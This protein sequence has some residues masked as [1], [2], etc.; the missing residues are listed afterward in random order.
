LPLTALPSEYIVAR[1]DALDEFEGA[2]VDF[3]FPPRGEWLRTQFNDLKGQ[4]DWK[5]VM[6]CSPHALYRIAIGFECGEV[7]KIA[8]SRIARSLTVENVSSLYVFSPLD[9]R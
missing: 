7:Q 2:K 9:K 1:A 5:G 6:P 4:P 8:L 3:E